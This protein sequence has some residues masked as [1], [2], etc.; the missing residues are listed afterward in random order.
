MGFSEVDGAIFLL[1]GGV[2]ALEDGGDGKAG[3]GIEGG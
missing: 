1:G 3:G 2:T